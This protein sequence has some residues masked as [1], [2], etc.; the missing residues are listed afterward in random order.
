MVVMSGERRT[1]TASPQRKQRSE[2]RGGASPNLRA[3]VIAVGSEM[4]TPTHVD[5]NSLFITERLNE[6]GIDLQGKTVAGDDRAVLKAIVSDAL[7]R[8]DLLI[9]TG[10]LGPTDDDLTRDVVADLIGRPLEYHEHIFEAIEKRFAARGLRT[11]EINRRQ[12]MVPQ[13][14]VVLP[15]KNGTAPGLWIEHDRKL[16][17]LLPGP[18]REL[19]PMF[20][21]VIQERLLACVGASRLFRR[22]LRITGQ[23]ESYVEEKMQP[24]Y[25]KWL[26]ART[27]VTTTILASLGQIELHL[28][29]VA[30]S[31]DEG[32]RALDG[33]VADVRETLGRDLFSTNGETM[34][35]IVGELLRA[36]RLR[37]AAAESCTGG[38]VMARLTEVPGS[39]DYVDRGVVVYSNESKTELLGVPASLISEHGAVSEPVAEAMAVGMARLA[40]TDVAVGITGV[41]GPGGG[42]PEKPVGM[43]AIASAWS[44]GGAVDTR[45]RTFNFVGGREMV[46]FQASQAALDMV[47]RWIT[48]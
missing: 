35:Q 46:R 28:T 33:A 6:I 31:A 44:R 34:Q 1:A 25:A 21:T 23:S 42:T 18:P 14:A 24:L 37:I 32:H 36:R 27:R 26:S 7:S 11:P 45:V 15:N 30:S 40:R 20:E 41:A 22:L 12:A 4:L 19:K 29:A 47:R 5:T 9:L 16:V 17:V 8:T 13:G 3:E 48:E 43:V 10:G 2:I 39:S 38:L